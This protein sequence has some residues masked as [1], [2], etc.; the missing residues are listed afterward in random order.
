[1]ITI[2][3]GPIYL[4]QNGP[5]LVIPPAL[6]WVASAFFKDLRIR[7]PTWALAL[8]YLL[9]YPAFFLLSIQYRDFRNSK[10]ARNHGAVLPP[11]VEDKSYWPGGLGLMM[12]TLSM[13]KDGYPGEGLDF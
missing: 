3:P 12:H 4:L 1:M 6:V 11:T 13:F 7:T 5:T 8:T 9:S 2:P 10:A